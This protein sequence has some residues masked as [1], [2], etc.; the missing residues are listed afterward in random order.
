MLI[1]YSEGEVR[2]SRSKQ[3]TNVVSENA[4]NNVKVVKDKQKEKT[5]TH[6]NQQSKR[7]STRSSG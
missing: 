7:R 6:I 4:N 1:F 3:K 5:V 2:N